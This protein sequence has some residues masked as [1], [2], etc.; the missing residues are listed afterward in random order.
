MLEACPGG[1]G[2]SKGLS[3]YDFAYNR[4]CIIY[5]HQNRFELDL[6]A[7]TG[8]HRYQRYNELVSEKSECSPGN[9]L[10]FRCT[11]WLYVPFRRPS[12]MK[13]NRKSAGYDIPFDHSSHVLGPGALVMVLSILIDQKIQSDLRLINCF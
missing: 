5:L 11:G 9:P 3:G 10:V 7:P 12:A 6:G 8:C 2:V 1:P 13:S 4:K